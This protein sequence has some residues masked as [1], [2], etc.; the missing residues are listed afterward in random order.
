[1]KTKPMKLLLVF[2]FSVLLLN[3]QLLVFSNSFTVSANP[4]VSHVWE[5]GCFFP[6]GSYPHKI[7]LVDAIVN[8]DVHV[9]KKNYTLFYDFTGDYY[10]YNHN[11]SNTLMLSNPLTYYLFPG[12]YDIHDMYYYNVEIRVNETLTDYE[13]VCAGNFHVIV[14][15]VTF[16]KQ[17]IVHLH[18]TLSAYSSSIAIEEI[19]YFLGTA[20]GWYNNGTFS[21]TVSFRVTGV[22]PNSYFHRGYFGT[23]GTTETCEVSS[24]EGGNQYQWTWQNQSIL[25]EEHVGISYYHSSNP[26]ALLNIILAISIPIGSLLMV[27]TIIAIV[28]TIKWIRKKRMMK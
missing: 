21:E 20:N 4:I 15:N 2:C 23:Q 26:D 12:C 16:P 1:M 3:F 27:L 28:F 24:I 9:P 19:I 7:E 14:C 17:Q 6:V 10:F 25:E 13:T 5:N 11:D 18:Y 8:F 22:Q